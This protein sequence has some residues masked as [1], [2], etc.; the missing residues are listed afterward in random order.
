MRGWCIERLAAAI[1][2]WDVQGSGID[3]PA[4]FI[5]AELENFIRTESGREEA[6]PGKHDDWVLALCIALATI[7]GAT[8]F[9]AEVTRNAEPVYREKQR[10]REL[11]A[12]RGQR[13]MR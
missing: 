5:L 7:D 3:C 11:A 9:R 2:E 4:E 12:K 1:R 10:Q 8:L 13:G 6:A